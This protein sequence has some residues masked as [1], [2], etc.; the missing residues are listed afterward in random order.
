MGHSQ[1]EKAQSRERIVAAAARQIRTGGLESVSI[2]E[3]MKTAKLTHGAFYGHFPS[4][5]ALIAAALDRALT[6]GE[7]RSVAAAGGKVAPT[8]K[9]ILNR[10]LSP[11]HRDDAGG[12]CAV[13]ALAADVGRA[14]PEVR[15]IMEQRLEKYFDDLAAAIGDDP[16]A[17]DLAVSAWCTMVGAVV[18]SRVFTNTERSD[19]ILRQARRSI[20]RLDRRGRELRD[21]D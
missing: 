14:D 9:S 18:L 16:D 19:A 20:L 4:R 1:A 10:Y 3:L 15:A 12:G 21:P 7:A 5:S 2:A 8:L 11:A 17:A 6:E 13:S